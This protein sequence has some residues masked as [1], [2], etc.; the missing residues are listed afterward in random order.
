MSSVGDVAGLIV[1]V[2]DQNTVPFHEDEGIIAHPGELLSIG[3]RRVSNDKNH[4]C[5]WACLCVTYQAGC[6]NTL[7]YVSFFVVCV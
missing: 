7:A 3:V 2:H 4:G 5:L 6:Y 1:V